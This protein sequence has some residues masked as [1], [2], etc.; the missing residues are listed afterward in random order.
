MI[1]CDARLLDRKVS[2]PMRMLLMVSNDHMS[3]RELY[4]LA[5]DN[6]QGGWATSFMSGLPSGAES[7]VAGFDAVVY[8]LGA[9]DRPGRVDEVKALL[10]S[11]VK[12]VT[13]VEGR[14][15][16]AKVD[17]LQAAGAFVV[18]HPVTIAGV[19][20]VLDALVA[21][22]KSKGGTNRVGFGERLRRT[23]IG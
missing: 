21:K 22:S 19:T 3:L 12:V 9:P 4:T 23:F 14:D 17:D 5:V 10:R 2:E 20:A 1:T 7:I 18:P 6:Q 15:S 8:E 16:A 11:G 13:H